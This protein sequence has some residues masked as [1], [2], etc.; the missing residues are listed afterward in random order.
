LA[1]WLGDSGGLEAWKAWRL[2]R[3]GR[4]RRL[5]LGEAEY[6]WRLGGL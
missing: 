6:A 4:L 3:L 5:R 1:A 2:R